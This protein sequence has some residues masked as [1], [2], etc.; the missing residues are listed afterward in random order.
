MTAKKKHVFQKAVQKA[1]AFVFDYAREVAQVWRD[2]PGTREKLMFI[3]ATAGAKLIHPD[4]FAGKEIAEQFVQENNLALYVERIFVSEGMRNSFCKPLRDGRKILFLVTEKHVHDMVDH[5]APLAQ[6]T[7]FVFDH[8]VGHAIVPGGT[9]ND[10]TANGA[11]CA[12]D[13]YATIRHLQRFDADSPTI[14]ALVA[15]RSFDFVFR[16][17]WYGKD[18]FSSPVVEKILEQRY[19]IDWNSLTPAETVRMARKFVL[20]YEMDTAALQMLENDFR[21]LHAQAKNIEYGSAAP[22]MELA[23][24]ILATD[25]SDVF[26]YGGAALQLCLDKGCGDTLLKGRYWNNVR[27]KLAEKQ[28]ELAAQA[29]LQPVQDVPAH[30]TGRSKGDKPARSKL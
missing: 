11:E 24:K 9:H 14:D 28:K 15:N 27:K 4:R 12:A 19:D 17:S 21:P 29:P 25:S 23:E 16:E 2:F 7:I 1:D 30:P 6:E 10:A 20:E 3:E 18:H 5:A 13:A 8:E 26:K 22:I